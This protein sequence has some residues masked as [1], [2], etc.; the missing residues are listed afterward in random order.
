[1]SQHQNATHRHNPPHQ[2]GS[3]ACCGDAKLH[4]ILDDKCSN[5]NLKNTG[6][7]C[8]SQGEPAHSPASGCCGEAEHGRDDACHAH[9]HYHAHDHSHDHDHAHHAHD[10]AQAEGC[11]CESAATLQRQLAEGAAGA[12]RYRFRIDAMDCPTEAALI[13]KALA[14]VDGVA[15][16]DFN[17]IE[18]VLI[19]RHDGADAEAIQTAIGR[20]GMQAVSLE[21]DRVAPA[22]PVP[23]GNDMLKLTAS[24]LLAAG[25]EGWAWFSG[26]DKGVVVAALAL[27]SILIAGLP[28]LRKGWIALRSGAM[29]IH[30][31]MSV[32]V[33]GA[34]AIGQWPEAAMVLFLFAIAEKLEA[35]SLARAGEAVR[36]LM[37]LA[38]ETAWLR[39]ADGGWLE[40]PVAGASIGS[41]A[42]VRPGERVPLDGTIVAGDSSFNEAPITGESL[43]VDKRVGDSVFAGSING[44]GLVEVRV[45]AAASGSVLARIID[46]VRSAQASKAPTQR[47]I[48]RFAR[49][50][51]PVVV[52]LAAACAVL[53]PLLGLMPLR[54]AVYNALVMLVIACPCALV[55]ATPVSVV[56]ALAAAA[57]A[58]MLVKGGAPL[59]VAARIDTVCFDKTG[60]LT[61]GQP[62]VTRVLALTADEGEIVALAAALDAH[63]THPLARA[64][65]DEAAKRGMTPQAANEV[66]E[67]A[68]RGV[69]GSV[70]GRALALGSARLAEEQD[71]MSDALRLALDSLDA[72]GEG[73]L[74][75]LEGARALGVLAVADGVRP[76]AQDTVARLQA[77]GV[78]TVMLSGDNPA[79]VARVAR[80]TGV[81][82]AHGGLLPED[83]L[84]RIHQLQGEGKVAMVGD[85]VNDAPALAQAELGV[86]MGAAGSDTALETA[87]VAL[88]DDRLE[89]LPALLKHAR[90][91]AGVL[92]VNIAVAL[93]IKLV[94]FGLALSGEATLWMAVFADVGASLMVIGNG[95]RLARKLPDGA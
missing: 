82:E 73:A 38:P 46:T 41:V 22:A 25:A 61:F 92:K 4:S 3:G 71:A 17:F 16:L 57:R 81:S 58:G 13:E 30:F 87:G 32:A 90:R 15:G 10:Q 76:E 1:M 44:G 78:R 11:A 52:G 83:K 72:Q 75:L 49:W 50:Y 69:F 51:T 14:K 24:G 19:V 42:R 33:I 85:G 31:L 9:R 80:L 95:L 67:R 34:V 59:E 53:L 77:M 35:M 43:P 23:A 6:E 36:Q 8:R 55:I 70:A 12:Q 48:D 66:N 79:V 45:T 93:L 20:V 56:S 54:E 94:F 5:K 18:R 27:S 2:T 28:T 63:S 47:F 26:A 40:T 29:N 88:M 39:Q 21:G 74:V 65:L 68:G 89:K 86:A 91:T 64:V 7:V 37:A 62:Q 84:A 60:T